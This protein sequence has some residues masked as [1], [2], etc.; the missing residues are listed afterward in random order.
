MDGICKLNPSRSSTGTT[1]LGE[2]GYQEHT[3]FFEIR[4]SY[5]HVSRSWRD[6]LRGGHRLG[7]LSAGIFQLSS[8]CV[9]CGV[10]RCMRMC[11]RGLVR[12]RE[13]L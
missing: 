3:L 10:E 2:A 1:E 7:K 8:L 9:I 13:T 4:V 11:W 12:G 6:V 5:G